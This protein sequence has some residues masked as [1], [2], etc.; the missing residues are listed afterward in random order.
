MKPE[1]EP[2]TRLLG[3]KMTLI[4]DAAVASCR[5]HG[6]AMGEL[7]TDVRVADPTA[8]PAEYFGSKEY[9]EGED[10]KAGH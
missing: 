9:Y 8:D 3:V 10:L 4:A 6:L 5:A 2:V 7:N 1:E